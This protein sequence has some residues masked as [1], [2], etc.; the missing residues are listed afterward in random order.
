[1]TINFNE[2]I[3]LLEQIATESQRDA[4]LNTVSRRLI[5]TRSLTDYSECFG[6]D[7]GGYCRWKQKQLGRPIVVADFCCAYA[8][9][10]GE[11]QE[12]MQDDVVVLGID[13]K[14]Y[15]GHEISQKNFLVSNVKSIPGSPLQQLPSGCVDLGLSL[16][17][18][19]FR[20]NA[21]LESFE[22]EGIRLNID[23]FQE[24][25][26]LFTPGAQGYFQ[27]LDYRGNSFEQIQSKTNAFL[28][29]KNITMDQG[30]I[31]HVHVLV[32]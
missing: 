18:V 28:Q 8:I 25:E 17:G 30:Y 19:P 13:G 29:Q 16:F 3:H 7:I 2:K 26:R 20:F 14:Y 1:M 11:L 23:F 21:H 6:L 22:E 24:L 4:E 10:L 31:K 32:P 27:S 5:N 12:K 9:A 15:E